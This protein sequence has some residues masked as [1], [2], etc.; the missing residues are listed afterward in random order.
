MVFD[1]ASELYVPVFFI[2]LQS[3]N[4]ETYWTA[5]HM[6]ICA[7]QWK[8]EASS[9]TSDF[10]VALCKAI[11]QQFPTAFSVKCYF[12]FKQANRRR[13]IDLGFDKETVSDFICSGGP[14]EQVTTLPPDELETKGKSKLAW[15]TNLIFILF[16]LY[17]SPTIK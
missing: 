14:F 15:H 4:Y 10:E 8:M 16:A 5:L 12:H 17:F 7:S 1:P 6:C 13:L 3:K 2:L 11:K 9:E